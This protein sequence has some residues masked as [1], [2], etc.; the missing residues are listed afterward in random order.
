MKRKICLIFLLACCLLT[1]CAA[2]TD[3]RVNHQLDLGKKY[4]L[5]F[6]YDKAMLAY[7]KALQLE[8]KQISAYRGLSD[9]FT[10]KNEIDSS[11]N[12]LKKGIGVAAGMASS[13]KDADVNRAARGLTDQIIIQLTDMGDRAAKKENYD[14]AIKYYGDLIVYNGEEEEPYLKLSG[15]YEATGDLQKALEV[16]QNAEITTSSMK[17][18]EERLTIRYE[19]KVKYEQLLGRLAAMIK[20]NDGEL[21]KEVLLSQDF[22]ELV[23]QLTEPLILKQ[24]SDQ[25]IVV[26]PN[27]YVYM[28]QM[29]N[30]KRGGY[31]DYYTNNEERYVVYSGF[32]KDDKPNGEG[33]IDTIVYTNASNQSPNFYGRGYFADGVAEGEFLLSVFYQDGRKYDYELNC[34]GG[35]PPAIRREDGKNVVS[36]SVTDGAHYYSMADVSI[37]AVPT[38][39]PDNY[40]S[41]FS[42]SITTNN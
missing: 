12:V 26:Y 1:G 25:Y 28:G 34:S 15:V 42:N 35:I 37:M 2:I 33:R 17:E 6:E 9:V 41:T 19:I 24:P 20:A 21:A 8:P 7:T 3:Y 40:K 29:E 13:E 5:E 4:L 30:Q 32:W 39:E 10:A 27:G 22:L 16:L 31:G 36:Y 23:S 14:R 18:E 11:I 38:F